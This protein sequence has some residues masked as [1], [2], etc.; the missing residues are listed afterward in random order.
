MATGFDSKQVINIIAEKVGTVHSPLLVL[1]EDYDEYYLKTPAN[2]SPELSIINEFLCTNLLHYWQISSP[3]ANI[4]IV[5][6]SII[7]RTL[8]SNHKKE[9]FKRSCFGSKSVMD[10]T[11]FTVAMSLSSKH[12]YNKFKRP[13]DILKIGLFDIWVE[14]D[15]RKPSN[16]NLLI[17]NDDQGIE[18]YPIDHAFIF[19]TRKY[20]DLNPSLDLAVSFN[21][22]ILYTDFAQ[23]VY[24]YTLK[25]NS[26]W[27]V[28]IR[29][30]FYLA[31]DNCKINYKAIIKSLP[32]DLGFTKKDGESLF[33]FLFSDE[34]NK[35]VF[36]DF[37]GRF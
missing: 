28:E 22:S 36:T 24:E 31:I 35:K 10:S 30:Y 23:K 7:D 32:P 16:P 19:G 21:D 20:T 9:Y 25:D 29:E 18:F 8:S 12:D 37:S 15:D 26:D 4:L 13:D 17:K 11:E 1:T 3:D 34:R 27:L 6:P 5:D 2:S 14:N 33:D